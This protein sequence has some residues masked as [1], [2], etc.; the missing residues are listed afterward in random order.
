MLYERWREIARAGR[1]EIALRDL[2]AGRQW[3]FRELALVTEQAGRRDSKFVFPQGSSSEFIF[4]VLDAWRSGQAVCPLESGQATPEFSQQLPDSVVHLK[5]TSAT[6]GAPRMVAFTAEQLAAD[7]ENIVATMGLRSDWPN[8]GVISLAHSYGFSNLVLPL[9]LHGIPLVL[10]EGSLPE[11]I[12]RNAAT[13]K[14]ITLA[15]VPALWQTWHDVDAIPSNVRLA[16]SAG[17]PLPLGLEQNVFAMRGLKIHNFYGA[18][19][20][21]GIAY[22]ATAGPRLDSSCVGAAMRNVGL[23]AADDGCLE[24]RSRAV[25]Q[26]YWPE[27]DQSLSDGAFHTSD[28]TEISY[29]LVYLRGRVTDQINVAGRKISPETIERVLRTHPVVR[30]CLVFGVPGADRDRGEKIVACVVSK[31]GASDETLKQFLLE[32]LPAW[33]VPRDWQFVE[34]LEVNQRGKLSRAEWR[35]R[36]LKK[37]GVV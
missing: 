33:Q 13:E 15:A 2:A 14:V 9:L 25:G 34:S 37:N 31:S 27:A 7:A 22:D 26:T 35:K 36:Y 29:G 18:S 19:E 11:T 24:V 5:T 20:C 17:A 21:G 30:D 3:T 4:S 8:L 6:T 16:I 32:K 23:S 12:R 1:D 10:A 28:L